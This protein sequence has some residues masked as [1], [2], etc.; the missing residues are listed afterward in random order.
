MKTRAT[1][2]YRRPRLQV[3]VCT[4]G[5]E[6]LHRLASRSYPRIDGVTYLISRQLPHSEGDV[7][8]EYTVPEPLRRDDI[9]IFTHPTIGL[10]VNRNHALSLAT[11]EIVLIS[12][13]DVDYTEEG[14]RRVIDAFDT[15][16]SDLLAFRY[17]SARNKKYYPDVEFDLLNPAKGYYISS[18]EIAFRLDAVRGICWFSPA[19]GIGGSRFRSGEEALFVE[20]LLRKGI[21]G[22][23]IPATICSH[24]SATTSGR[25][26]AYDLGASK[27]ALCAYTHRHTW[28]LRMLVNSWRDTRVKSSGR[29]EGIAGYIR[30]WLNG[31]RIM[32][33]D[34]SMVNP[35]Y[36]SPTGYINDQSAATQ[37]EERI[38]MK[39]NP[40]AEVKTHS[41]R[42][43]IVIPVHN[44]GKWLD[45]MFDSVAAQTFRDFEIIAVDDCST[46][47]SMLR[48][49][50]EK[51]RS[52]LDV[53]VLH[54]SRSL[55]NCYAPRRFGS[56]E[57]RGEY[58][59]P[60]DADDCIAPDFLA[61]LD[62]RIRQ[63]GADLV[64]GEMYRFH[65]DSPLTE[66]VRILPADNVDTSRVVA[67][68]ENVCLTLNGW[69]IGTGGCYS[70]GLYLRAL[71]SADGV[72]SG[73]YAVEILTR[74]VMAMSE[75]MAFCRA[76]YYYRHNPTSVTQRPKASSFGFLEADVRLRPVIESFFG[77]DSPEAAALAAQTFHDTASTMRRLAV[78]D[79]D[80]PGEREKVV[81]MARRAYESIDRRHLRRHTSMKYRAVMAT[82]FGN[83]MRILGWLQRKNMLK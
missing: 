2:L 77:T 60:L 10:A 39:T 83:A 51:K 69:K 67:G 45:A 34:P 22:R 8:G 54:T 46:D 70:R 43:S 64:Y 75:K 6:A 3:L 63:T 71:L 27:G 82:G 68:R 37:Q 26:G 47:D 81:E 53:K 35:P 59:V 33:T 1:S 31:A 28:P 12:D 72:V 50:N 41:H 30:G 73:V 49:Q 65:G 66:G 58:I 11:G 57:A 16:D 25:I 62:E 19:F 44:A 61:L 24:D 74:I 78:I 36:P 76:G 48:L 21:K 15:H 56:L 55:G 52:G 7:S 9:E 5:K 32:L 38:A 29:H 14:L 18:I 40:A 23:F 79:F 4:Y 42:F 17:S 20:T 13:D 80:D